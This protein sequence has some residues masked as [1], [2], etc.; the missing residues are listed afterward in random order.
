M[1]LMFLTIYGFGLGRPGMTLQIE[2]IMVMAIAG[3]AVLT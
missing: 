3:A 2:F 1:S